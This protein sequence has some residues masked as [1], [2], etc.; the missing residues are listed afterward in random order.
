MRRIVR[1]VF[2][3][4]LRHEPRAVTDHHRLAQRQSLILAEGRR[5][6]RIQYRLAG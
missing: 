6:V 5:T 1:S 2:P 3:Q 4:R